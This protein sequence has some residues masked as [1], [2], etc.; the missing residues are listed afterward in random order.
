M[1]WKD[2]SSLKSDGNASFAKEKVTTK[3]A[4]AEVTDDDGKV[5]RKAE[6]K[7]EREF[8]A[9]VQKSWNGSTGVANADSKREYSLSD[10]ERAKAQY[11]SEM[12]RAKVQSDELAK[13]ITDFKKL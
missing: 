6:A 12:A 11:D 13:A 7:Q 2:Y 8:I 3:E 5:V 4:V 9:L 1:N 10:L